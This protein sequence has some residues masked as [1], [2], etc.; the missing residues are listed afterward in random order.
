MA[1]N[2]DFT[3]RRVE[4]KLKRQQKQCDK[5]VKKALRKH[6]LGWTTRD[7]KGL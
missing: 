1:K 2:K 3:D 5:E 7:G 4:K 6:R